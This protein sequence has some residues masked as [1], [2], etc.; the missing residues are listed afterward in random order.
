MQ[1]RLEFY[2]QLH[3]PCCTQGSSLA[4]CFVQTGDKP[5]IGLSI[6]RLFL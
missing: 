6:R 1:D 2:G 4:I 5:Y 3:T